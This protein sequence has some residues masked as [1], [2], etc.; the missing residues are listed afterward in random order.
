MAA[1]AAFAVHCTRCPVRSEYRAV[2]VPP[3]HRYTDS[4]GVRAAY[5]R[6]HR[7]QQLGWHHQAASN[8]IDHFL[9][10]HLPELSRCEKRSRGRLTIDTAPPCSR[11]AEN[12]P[13]AFLYVIARRHG[14]LP[15][16]PAS[17]IDVCV[18]AAL[19]A[20]WLF[21]FS[22]KETK[23]RRK[24]ALRSSATMRSGF[25]ESSSTAVVQLR[26]LKRR[27]QP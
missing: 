17:M 6:Q 18:T 19:L 20:L 24:R 21:T 11:A 1:S 5:L 10:Q 4:A 12:Q 25:T 3:R 7:G 14:C 13:T 22:H 8:L 9:R 26:R 2:R 15:I 27:N 23:P 16:P